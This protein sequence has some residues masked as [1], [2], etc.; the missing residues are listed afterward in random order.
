VIRCEN[1]PDAPKTHQ[2]IRRQI[3]EAWLRCYGRAPSVDTPYTMRKI[4]RSEDV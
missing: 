1:F 4:P 3:G 2:D